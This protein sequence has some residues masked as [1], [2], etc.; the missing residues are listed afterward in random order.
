MDSK[1]GARGRG[2]PK[3]DLWRPSGRR[4][5]RHSQNCDAHLRDEAGLGAGTQE[6]LAFQVHTFPA[7]RSARSW[8]GRSA[9]AASAQGLVDRPAYRALADAGVDECGLTTLAGR[10]VGAPFVGAAT[11]AVVVAELL[12]MALGEHRYEVVDGSLRALEHRQAVRVA[13]EAAFNPGSARAA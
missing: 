13:A 11:A 1:I 9:A 3:A 2:A 7:S 10:T 6:Y 8:W 4:E 12:R 5:A